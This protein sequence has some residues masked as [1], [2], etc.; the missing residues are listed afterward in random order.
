MSEGTGWPCPTRG[1]VAD[2]QRFQHGIELVG[3]SYTYGERLGP[4]LSDISLT[5]AKGRRVAFVGPSGAGKT[6][7]VDVLL[8][9]L[10]PSQGQVLVDGKDIQ[11]NLATW[12]ERVVGYIPQHIYL[13][14]DTV[15][16]NIALGVPDARIDEAQVWAALR[17]A[18]LSKTWSGSC[19]K[20]WTRQSARMVSGYPE[21]SDSGSALRAPSTEP[22]GPGA[23]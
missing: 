3:V 16:R 11:E 17:A 22:G 7:I 9:L 23:R 14:D 20:A 10:T 21:A 12:R 18:Q 19:L 2:F 4:A 1:S 8:G 5:I 13:L 15:R 6:T